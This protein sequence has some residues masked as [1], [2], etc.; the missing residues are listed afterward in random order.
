[1]RGFHVTP[2]GDISENAGLGGSGSGFLDSLA[3]IAIVGAMVYTVVGSWHLGKYVYE[4]LHH[5][6]G[7]A[8][9]GSWGSMYLAMGWGIIWAVVAVVLLLCGLVNGRPVAIVFGLAAFAGAIIS[10]FPVALHFGH[11]LGTHPW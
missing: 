2:W 7:P 10:A 6:V 3:L 5:G 4:V 9:A 1:M 8:A 11:V